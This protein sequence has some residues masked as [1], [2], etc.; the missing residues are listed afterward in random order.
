MAYLFKQRLFFSVVVG[1]VH[2]KF[3]AHRT[4][5]WK[6]TLRSTSETVEVL[7]EVIWTLLVLAKHIPFEKLFCCLKKTKPANF[8]FQCGVLSIFSAEDIGLCTHRRK[9]SHKN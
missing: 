9:E 8:P 1:S 7:V 2:K 4:L 5:L 6:Y 3:K